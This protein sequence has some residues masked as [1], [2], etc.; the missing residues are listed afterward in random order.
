MAGGGGVNEKLRRI[1]AMIRALCAE[2]AHVGVKP[3]RAAREAIVLAAWNAGL[4]DEAMNNLQARQAFNVPCDLP[5]ATAPEAI[6]A[7]PNVPTEN[8]PPVPHEGGVCAVEG[9]V[10]ADGGPVYEF[11]H[12]QPNGAVFTH[13]DLICKTDLGEMLSYIPK[14]ETQACPLDKE[15][16]KGKIYPQDVEGIL[17]KETPE[18]QGY[19]ERFNRA[20]AT[21]AEA[22]V[23]GRRHRKTRRCRKHRG[24][25]AQPFFTK[26]TE[27]GCVKETPYQKTRKQRRKGN[28]NRRNRTSHRGRNQ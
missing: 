11:S 22:A 8:P 24:G 3:E 5:H 20:V 21:A 18:Y 17:G 1:Q 19:R 14:E 26:M 23:G 7:A 13:T 16:C 28:L 6:V 15:K 27:V 2:Q 10:P 9:T 12:K 4:G 25:G